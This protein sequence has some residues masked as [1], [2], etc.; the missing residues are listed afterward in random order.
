MPFAP[1]HA[2]SQQIV[3]PIK[4]SDKQ[5]GTSINPCIDTVRKKQEGEEY[6]KSHMN[7]MLLKRGCSLPFLRRE[8]GAQMRAP[9]SERSCRGKG[10]KSWRVCKFH[11]QCKVLWQWGDTK[12]KLTELRKQAE[13]KNKTWQRNHVQS[14]NS[15]KTQVCHNHAEQTC[16]KMQKELWRWFTWKP[17]AKWCFQRREEMDGTEKAFKGIPEVNIPEGLGP[18]FHQSALY[19]RKKK[20][21]E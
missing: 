16:T 10:P 21:R 14:N 12:G 17:K 15:L 6:S 8:G 20:C 1:T 4:P 2:V 18:S 11:G 7:S 5:K 19:R 3:E 13:E 9:Q